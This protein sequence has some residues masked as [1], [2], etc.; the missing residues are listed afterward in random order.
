VT[1]VDSP[2]V[3]TKVGEPQLLF[4]EARQRRRRRQL[5]A[6]IVLVGLLLVAIGI[7][8]GVMASGGGR[9]PSHAPGSS[10]PLLTGS[11]GTVSGTLKLEAGVSLAGFHGLPGTVSLVGSHGV[12]HTINVGSDGKFLMHVPAGTYTAIGKSPRYLTDGT[13]MPCHSRSP[14]VVQAGVTSTITVV[15][16]GM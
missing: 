11:S 5:V 9:S 7:T 15:C 8:A 10:E 3:E 12:T 14:I 1:V 6:G 13:E 4:A 2:H 16:E